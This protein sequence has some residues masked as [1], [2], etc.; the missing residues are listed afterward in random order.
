MVA[1]PKA[2]D[3]FSTTLVTSLKHSRAPGMAPAAEAGSINWVHAV[4]SPV[5]NLGT[6]LS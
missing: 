5:D 2:E 4:H 1:L 3:M 6:H